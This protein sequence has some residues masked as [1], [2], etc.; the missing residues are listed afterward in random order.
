MAIVGRSGDVRESRE[1]EAMSMPTT[2]FGY[3]MHERIVVALYMESWTFTTDNGF[4]RI[5]STKLLWLK[6]EEEAE[7]VREIAAMLKSDTERQHAKNYLEGLAAGS[8][9]VDDL[10]RKGAYL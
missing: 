5:G 8:E 4:G 2:L 10:R 3:P 7:A 1:A 6:T 9:H